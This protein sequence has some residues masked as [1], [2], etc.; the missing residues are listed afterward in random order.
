MVQK[1]FWR[2]VEH[3]YKPIIAMIKSKCGTIL[4]RVDGDH[5]TGLGHIYRAKSLFKSLNLYPLVLTLSPDD[6]IS[7]MREWGIEV[8][9]IRD[10]GKV[11]EEIISTAE[12]MSTKMLIQ[13]IR[14]TSF[15]SMEFLKRSGLKIVNFDDL[16]SGRELADLLID[17][18][19]SPDES[20]DSG[21]LF[22]KSYMVLDSVYGDFNVIEKHTPFC[23]E[24]VVITM[25]GSDPRGL[26]AWAAEIIAK[27][28]KN[29]DLTVAVGGSFKN[30]DE[31]QRL[32]DKYC[33]RCLRDV[34]NMAELFFENDLA[35]ISGGI[36]LYEASAVGIPS[37]VLPQVEHQYRIGKEFE[38][39]Q[40]VL[41]PFDH[42]QKDEAKFIDAVRFLSEDGGLR[43]SMSDKGK[44]L[45]DGKG[46]F[47]VSNAIENLY[48]KY[49]ENHVGV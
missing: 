46:V 19:I 30:K 12:R 11:D 34:S 28:F 17:A 4:Y 31:I 37:V 41:S 14:D 47:R 49:E 48:K 35:V 3:F 45:V 16:G 26:T 23:V 15:E 8:L 7:Q 18:N 33:F 25:G 6:I 38:K 29:F 13:D 10:R 20:V 5:K 42:R 36:T 1:R 21:K 40:V 9:K 44:M 22:G 2:L 27:S 32:A 39:Q 24:K 43:K